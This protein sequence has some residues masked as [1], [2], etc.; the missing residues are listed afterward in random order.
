MFSV[1][2]LRSPTPQTHRA[3]RVGILFA[4]FPFSKALKCLVCFHLILCTSVSGQTST[5]FGFSGVCSWHGFRRALSV[6]EQFSFSPPPLPGVLQRLVSF[7]SLPTSSLMPVSALSLG[8][9]RQFVPVFFF[10]A[11]QYVW[12]YIVCSAIIFFFSGEKEKKG[13]RG[14]KQT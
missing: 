3:P 4:A 12:S 2:D 9:A 14:E 10:H 11:W 8:I 6:F 1:H 7:S 5:R 13:K